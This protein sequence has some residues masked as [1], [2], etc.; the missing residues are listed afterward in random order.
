[1][2]EVIIQIEWTGGGVIVQEACEWPGSMAGL[3]FH[4]QH[5]IKPQKIGEV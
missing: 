2:K 1:M 3:H 5:H 4:A